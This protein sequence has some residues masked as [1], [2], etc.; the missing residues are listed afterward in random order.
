MEC[1]EEVL[2]PRWVCL[3][4]V[5]VVTARPVVSGVRDSTHVAVLS[6]L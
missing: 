2:E 3:C 4:V 5:F 6:C 1:G